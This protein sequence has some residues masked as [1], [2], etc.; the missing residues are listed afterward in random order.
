V[1]PAVRKYVLAHRGVIASAV[2]RQP[3][4]RVPP[5]ALAEIEALIDRQTRRLMELG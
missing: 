5:E 4:A 3:A 1:G 2:Q